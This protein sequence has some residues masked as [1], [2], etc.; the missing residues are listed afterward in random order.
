MTD[1]LRHLSMED[2]RE[3]VIRGSLSS[4]IHPCSAGPWEGGELS[5]SMDNIVRVNHIIHGLSEPRR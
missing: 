3:V 5:L 2:I 1:L 4:P